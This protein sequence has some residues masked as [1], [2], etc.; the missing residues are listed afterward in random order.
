MRVS[1]V[2]LADPLSV[3]V[4]PW[5]DHPLVDPFFFSGALASQICFISAQLAVRQGGCISTTQQLTR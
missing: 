2:S 4:V 5:P 3:S 1:W